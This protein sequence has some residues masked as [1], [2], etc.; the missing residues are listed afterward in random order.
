VRRE[1][2]TKMLC[3]A[4]R[5]GSVPRRLPGRRRLPAEPGISARASPLAPMFA[6][7]EVITGARAENAYTASL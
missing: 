2:L 6:V 5:G 3:R 7:E 4:Q 1:F